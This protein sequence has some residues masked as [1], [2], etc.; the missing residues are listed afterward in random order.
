MRWLAPTCALLAACNAITGA[1]DLV[2]GD[3]AGPGGPGADAGAADATVVGA[4]ASPGDDAADARDA[5]GDVKVDAPPDGGR[6]V[7][8]TSAVVPGNF[9]VTGGLAAGD[10]LCNQLASDA[11]LPGTYVAWLSSSTVSA[12]SRVTGLGPW[13]RRDGVLVT[14]KFALGGDTISAPINRTETGLDLSTVSGED[15]VWT[16]TRLGSFYS[17]NCN[18]WTAGAGGGAAGNLKNTGSGWTQT[19]QPNCGNSLHLY[20]FEN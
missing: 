15:R 14:S 10:A 16:G 6:T 17:S 13:Y 20:C 11:K 7:F 8:V 18:D 3:D 12:L 5:E 1:S 19:S 9:G 2:V 4:D